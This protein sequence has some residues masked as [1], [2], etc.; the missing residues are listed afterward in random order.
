[1]PGFLGGGS[2][3]SGTGGEISF[4]KEFIDP[5][6]KLRVSQPQNLID[7]DFEYGLQPTK[8]E[9]VELINN[10]PSFFSKSGDTTIPN[11]IAITTNAGT[12]EITVKTGLDHGLAV[13]IPINVSGTKSITADGSYII[14]SIPNS[15]T[16]TYLCRDNQNTT[17]SIE[18]LYSSIITGEFFQGSQ[19][20]LADSE[21]IITDGLPLSTLTVKTGSTHGFG[22]DTPFYFLNL[23]STISQEFQ[24]ANTEAKSFDSSNSATAQTF[25]GSNTLS[26]INI[27]WSN[28]GVV[29]G[30]TSNISSVN[31]TNDTITVAHGTENF[32]ARPIGTPLYYDVTT[33]SGFFNENPR[34]VVYLKTTNQLGTSTST[35][36]VSELPDGDPIDIVTTITGTFQIANQARIF[37]GNNVNLSTE[38]IITVV[39]DPEQVFDAGNNLGTTGTV[40]SYSGSNVTVNSAEVLDWYFGTMVFYNTTGSAATGLTNNTT[41]FIDSFFRQGTSNNYSFTLKPLPTGSV[42]TSI[43]GGTGT[44]TF[45]QIGVSIDKDIF[46]VKDN[47]FVVNDMIEYNYPVGSRFGVA[48]VDQEKNYY[49][50]TVRYDAHNFTLNETTG[51]IIPR[52]VTINVNRGTAITPTTVTT[53]G[54]VAPISY[55]VTTGV[56][57][58]G[59]SINTSSG[60][61][62]GTPVEVVTN[63]QVIITGTDSRGLQAIQ[64]LDIT[65]NPTVGSITPDT[66]SRTGLFVGTAMTPT[67]A[68]TTN[69]VAP[70][71]WSVFS[72]T[73][74]AGLTLN[75]SNGVVSGT[76]NEV[77]NAPGRTV[78]IRARDVGNLDAF[79]THTYQI[80]PRPELYSFTS[81][82]FTSGGQTG[83]SG[84]NITQAR[85]GVGNPSWAPTYLNMTQN[86]KMRWTVPAT[87]NYRIDCYGAKGGDAPG[88]RGGYGARIQGDFSF[89]EGTILQILVG[90]PGVNTSHSQDGQPVASGGGWSGVIN[91]SDSPLIIAGGGGGGARNSWTN[92]PGRGGVTGQNGSR[93][94][95]SI[96]SP[97]GTGGNG[98]SGDTTGGP[99][100]GFFSNA[101]AGCGSGDPARRFTSGESANG[102]E[103]ARCWGGGNARGG[104]GGGGGG[105]GL[106]AGGGGGYSGGAGGQWSS[107]QSGGGGGSINNGS[108]Q[109]NFGDSNN[110]NGQVIITRI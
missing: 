100:A 96:N 84:P 50:I 47:G 78:V 81:A 59:L 13:G 22:V 62:S 43:S 79:Q 26:S 106:A 88:Q 33:S 24:A 71:T 51:D 2:S 38:Q 11:I 75:T 83:S 23:N 4:P 110:G 39:K 73:L 30:I 94:D 108:N 57:P 7:T 65:V 36:Q 76:P 41:Y 3:S 63:R 54:L 15:T 12:R 67:T 68:T 95:N 77:I 20:R 32:N 80:N 16:F 53:V 56:L 5:V 17:A 60:V 64:I 55:A 72:G 97:A 104:F 99:G 6:T 49:F 35:F 91:T 31:T 10:T 102:G 14:N 45:K 1:M 103:S 18:D 40:T 107:N 66:I 29:A 9:T 48:A 42:I 101:S 98:A 87:G 69:L 44:Q 58:N 37:A 93:W 61:V 109:L 28:S 52:N 82:T 92:A 34:G 19:L 85:A 8:W 27:D 46:H 25:D 21:G 70:I 90:Q 105:G 89:T 74:P 86:G